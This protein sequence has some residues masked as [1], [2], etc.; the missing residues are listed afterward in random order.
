MAI[1]SSQSALDEKQLNEVQGVRY[2]PGALCGLQKTF[3]LLSQTQLDSLAY[4]RRDP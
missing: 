4:P 1:A 2:L 3:F